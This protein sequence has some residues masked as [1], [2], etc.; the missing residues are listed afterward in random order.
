MESE[1]ATKEDRQ[2]LDLKD[3]SHVVVVKNFVYLD[4]ASIFQY[5]ESRH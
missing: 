4:D 5:T 3:M 1:E 2:Y